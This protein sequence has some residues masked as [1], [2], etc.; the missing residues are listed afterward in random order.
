MSATIPQLDPQ[1]WQSDG[2]VIPEVRDGLKY[3]IG[4]EI[5]EWKGNSQDVQTC[6]FFS[7]NGSTTRPSLGQSA[8]LDAAE[9]MRALEAA[10][11]AWDDGNGEWPTMTVEGRIR[12]M[13]KFIDRMKA[14]REEVVE[15]M[16]WEI[17][18][19]LKDSENEFDRTVKYIIDSIAALKDMSAIRLASASKIN[20]LPR[21]AA[22]RLAQL[23]A[24]APTTT[25]STRLSRP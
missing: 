12:A 4:G 13:E 17:G 25:R 10:E 5:K 21:F 3:L 2:R 18:K 16:M 23:F 9:A 19:T 20:G 6:L 11:K 1:N 24:W 15:R 22:P 7:S 8:L 14:V